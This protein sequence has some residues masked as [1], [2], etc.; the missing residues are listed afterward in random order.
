MSADDTV[1]FPFSCGYR[2]IFPMKMVL[3]NTYSSNFPL[4]YQHTL[5][6]RTFAK[7]PF[8]LVRVLE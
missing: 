2:N 5:L 7:H 4:I 8:L 3:Y 6:M 1:F